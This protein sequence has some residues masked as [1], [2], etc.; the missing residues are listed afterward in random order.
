MTTPTVPTATP[1]RRGAS[2]G[3]LA[4]GGALSL[5]G[6]G[7]AAGLNVGLVILV[8]RGFSQA[9]AGVFFAATSVFLLGLAI[10]K[11]GTQTGLVYFITRFRMLGQ[12]TPDR[13]RRLFGVAF[14]PVV[15][16]STVLGVTLYAL[17][18]WLAE[19][20][21]AGAPGHFTGYLR[22]LAVFLPVA[23]L[24]ETLLAATRGYRTQRATVVLDSI[25]RPVGQAVLVGT[26]VVTAGAPWLGFA[27]AAPYL[28]AALLAWLW[29]GSLVRPARAAD[30]APHPAGGDSAGD[31]LGATFW[32]YTWPRTFASIAQLALQRFDIILVAALLGPA[33][34]AIYT[35]ATR[36]LVVGQLGS[37]AISTAVQ[38]Q[39]GEQ[40][41]LDDTA[42]ART[43]YRT[44]TA[45]LMLLTWPLYLMCAV[46]AEPI[47][48]LFGRGYDAGVAVILVLTGAMLVAT[49]CGMVDMVLSMSGRTTWNLVNTLAAL[50][51]NVVVDLLLIP[52]V[53][54]IG[55]AIGW[56]ASIVFNNIVPL[57]QVGLRLRLHPF[58]SSTLVAAALSALCFAVLPFGVRAT[59]GSGTLPLLIATLVGVVIYAAGCWRFRETLRL[60]SL[61]ALLPRG[62][63]KEKETTP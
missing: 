58:G 3:S 23:A 54:I 6:A 46:F 17:A 21:V 60:T 43:L 49:G 27:W 62:M 31:R 26:V 37:K 38:P 30:A 25:G 47:L 29:L 28:P 16:A 1:P 51:V 15:V 2:L 59:A 63:K 44:G 61:R 53:G 41:A 8:T 52:R 4:R 45:W 18:P 40:L 7:V 20:S 34:A 48:G 57:A 12:A 10:G 56:A 32:R 39:L 35:A 24:F 11:L 22:S 42:A 36:F 9:Q 14:A 5:V 33:E 50:A 19:V 55:A 13:I